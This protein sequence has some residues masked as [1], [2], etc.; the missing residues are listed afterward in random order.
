MNS[1]TPQMFQP[2]SPW[3]MSGPR[4]TP[5]GIT[6]TQSVFKQSPQMLYN[7]PQEI[8][9]MMMNSMFQGWNSQNYNMPASHQLNTPHKPSVLIPENTQTCYFGACYQSNPGLPTLT[10]WPCDTCS[11]LRNVTLSSKIQFVVCCWAILESSAAIIPSAEL[12]S[13]C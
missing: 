7:S 10:Y 6:N 9:S 5:P 13:P 2:H 8:M 3:N 1:G 11:H 12:T 4:F